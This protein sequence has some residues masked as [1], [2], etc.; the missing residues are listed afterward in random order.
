MPDRRQSRVHWHRSAVGTV[1]AVML[2]ACAGREADSSPEDPASSTNMALDS[3]A[4]ERTPCFGRCP[5]Y[6]L[7]IAGTGAVHVESASASDSLDATFSDS[8]PP[9]A[10]SAL[11]ALARAI[12][13]FDLPDE[14]TP[15]NQ[16]VCKLAATDHPSAIVTIAIG[17]TVKRVNHY[18]GCHAEVNGVYGDAYPR[19]TAFEAAID[20]AARVER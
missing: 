13:F 18:H 6:R 17:D 2:A 12:D 11:L 16:D 4:L 15:A 9:S 7:R 14:I 20:S 3:I 10:A 5:V 19:L 1:L 8:I